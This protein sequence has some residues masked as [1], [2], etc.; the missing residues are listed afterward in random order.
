MD[1]RLH[2]FATLVESGGYT[3]A[4]RALNI[5]QPALSVAIKNLEKE[6]GVS[7]VRI[8]HR[9]V[10]LTPAGKQTYEAALQHR[11]VQQRLVAELAHHTKQLPP[12]R[13]GMIDSVASLLGDASNPLALLETHYDVSI[14]VANTASLWSDLQIGRLDYAICVA[15]QHKL[16]G[17]VAKQ[18]GHDSLV[19]VAAPAL[20]ES[21]L[22]S[23]ARHQPIDFI[24]YLDTSYTSQLITANMAQSQ[25]RTRT[26]LQ[27]SSP[28]VMLQLTL[29][30]RGATVL[31]G[32]LVE[33][34]LKNGSLITLPNKVSPFCV[35]RLLCVLGKRDGHTPRDIDDFF[36]SL[37]LL[38]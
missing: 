31:P 6:L 11:A 12:L 23:I 32:R 20:G 2:K 10:K 36:T 8:E 28:D 5:S 15:S 27:S 16:T 22:C 18:L 38:L 30:G 4:A 37:K 26:V 25:L 7:L 29:Q 9:Q 14:H 33:P 3:K 19:L 34:H 35:Q 1:N 21:V 13:I 24:A 17:F